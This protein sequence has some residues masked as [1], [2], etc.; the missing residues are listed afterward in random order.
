MGGVKMDDALETF[1]LRR[2]AEISAQAEQRVAH[3]TVEKAELLRTI[4]DLE[5]RLTEASRTEGTNHVVP[6]HG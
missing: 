4:K 2:I 5:D 6:E 1:Y 3:L